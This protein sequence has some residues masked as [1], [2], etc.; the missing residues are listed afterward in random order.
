MVDKGESGHESG[1]GD[2]AA[3]GI[4]AVPIETCFTT[5]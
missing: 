5:K 3:I 4:P 1:K 2:P